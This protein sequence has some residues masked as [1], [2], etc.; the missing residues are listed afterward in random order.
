MSWKHSVP[1]LARLASSWSSCFVLE[2]ALSTIMPSESDTMICYHQQ[3]ITG[4]A[5]HLR[6]YWYQKT[7]LGLLE[8]LRIKTVMIFLRWQLGGIVNRG[9]LDCLY[10][11]HGRILFQVSRLCCGKSS[12]CTSANN[13]NFPPW[14]EGWSVKL[15]LRN[16]FTYNFVQENTEEMR[17]AEVG[18]SE[19]E[20][21]G[22]VSF[23]SVFDIQIIIC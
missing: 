18:L 7:F 8:N 1:F 2:S 16:F 20:R 4:G 10:N 14:S 19:I 9:A 6:H 12:S 23:Y 17:K 11:P 15:S 22:L 5:S 13:I 3:E 21:K